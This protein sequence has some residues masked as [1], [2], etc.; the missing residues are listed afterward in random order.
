MMRP[1][2]KK[3]VSDLA[4]HPVRSL[5]VIASIAIGLFAIG[6]IMSVYYGLSLD[7]PASYIKIN[8]A[9]IQVVSTNFDQDFVDHIS[10]LPEVENADGQRKMGMRVYTAPNTWSQIDLTASDDFTKKNVSKVYVVEGKFPPDE[11]EIVVD[12]SKFGDLN[13]KLGD[14]IQIKTS[15]DMIRNFKL[16]GIVHDLTIGSASGGGGFFLAP[17]QGYISMDSV[18]RLDETDQFNQLLITVKQGKNDQK[19]IRSVADTVLDEYDRN[20]IT[21][22]SSVTRLQT[23]HP[24]LTYLD[25]I[26]AILIIMGFLVLFLSGFLITNTLAALL[27]PTNA[28]DRGDENSWRQTTSDQRSLCSFDPDL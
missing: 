6:M 15:S 17:I 12:V 13:A 1:R 7:M 22:L 25:A 19:Y 8:P 9:N 28:A 14:E 27:E 26:A 4:E 21:S 10:N 16:V 20:N 3:V 23:E 5:L 2:W 24:I 11:R 18:E